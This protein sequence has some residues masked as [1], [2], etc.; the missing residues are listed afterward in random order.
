MIGNVLKFKFRMKI[1]IE[2]Q[3]LYHELC[4]VYNVY[5]GLI[6]YD[7]ALLK[8]S[9]MDLILDVCRYSRGT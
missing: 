1:Q 8:W 2:T 3:C 5:V 4:Y 6:V 9:F 7:V